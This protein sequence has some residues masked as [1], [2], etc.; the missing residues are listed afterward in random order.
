[1]T[2]TTCVSGGEYYSGPEYV[3]VILKA[4]DSI[5]ESFYPTFTIPLN[6]T[7]LTRL[8]ILEPKRSLL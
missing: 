7:N 3:S 5:L 2:M 1:M 6:Q 4:M 8:I